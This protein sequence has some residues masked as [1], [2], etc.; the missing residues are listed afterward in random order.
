MTDEI[1]FSGQMDRILRQYCQSYE[2]YSVSRG[3]SRYYEATQKLYGSAN[4][5]DCDYCQAP[6]F[7]KELDLLVEQA[8]R[9][10]IDACTAYLD[11][12]VNLWKCNGVIYGVKNFGIPPEAVNDGFLM[13][14]WVYFAPSVEIIEP[15]SVVSITWPFRVHW[16]KTAQYLID[17]KHQSD[18]NFYRGHQQGQRGKS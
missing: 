14:R 17:A 15:L 11:G 18:L 2:G 12:F 8:R 9:Q 16:M 10:S 3:Y 1:D 7:K 5:E 6:P 13:P 4:S